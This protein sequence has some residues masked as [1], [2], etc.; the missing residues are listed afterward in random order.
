MIRIVR[1]DEHDDEIAACDRQCFTADEAYPVELIPS[2]EC[3]VALDGDEVVGYAVA[4]VI[5]G[6]G[7]LDR[8]GV[9]PSHAGQGVGKRLVRAWL[10]WARREGCPHAWTY[11]VESNAQSINALIGCGLRAWRPEWARPGYC[12]WRVAL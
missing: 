4:H 5:Q 6:A 2:A 8:Y 12:V 1:T 11:T 7:Y 3:W 9:L 10:R